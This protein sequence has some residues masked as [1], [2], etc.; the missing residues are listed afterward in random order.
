MRRTI[1]LIGMAFFLL[2]VSALGYGGK[3]YWDALSDAEA[4]R[5]RA[6]ELI[7]HGR[8]EDSLLPSHLAILI[9]V[10]DPNFFKH[11]GV[12]VATPGAGL[13]TITQSAAKRLAFERFH[14]GFGKIRQTGYALGLERRLSKSQ[15]LTLWLDTLEMGNGPNGWMSGF[16]AASF[17]IYGRSP[18]ELT[19][20][21]F[22]RLIAV[23]IAPATYDLTRN[24]PRLNERVTRIQRLVARECEPAGVSDVW[25]EGCQADANK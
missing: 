13:T 16:H 3:G 6:D 17:T 25:L 5:A 19:E 2:L 21:E 7:A 8:G 20:T 10:E 22:I 11:G 1:K 15:I 24:D 9:S 14:P 18:N 12:D 4:L 23:L